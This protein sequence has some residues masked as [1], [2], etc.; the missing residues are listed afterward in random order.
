MKR[1]QNLEIAR[2]LMYY[3]RTIA[4]F[5]GNTGETT[6]L[7]L[8]RLFR[9]NGWFVYEV[10]E[11]D[12]QQ[13][14]GDRIA[15]ILVICDADGFPKDLQPALERYLV[16]NGRVFLFG[17]P[18]SGLR[19]ITET[20][21]VLEG[22]SPLYKLYR[23]NDCDR[24]ETLPQCITS[25]GIRGEFPYAICPKAR[26]LG[27][28]YGN[29][30][31]CRMIPLVS[32]RKDGGRDGGKRGTVAYFM[33]SDT[34]GHMTCTPGTRLG[35]VSPITQGSA[36]AV[37]GLPL[38]SVLETCGE[39]I[40][41]MMRALDRGIF[42]F[43][44]GAD[45]YVIRP[46]EEIHVG[47][48]IVSASRD[49]QEVTVRFCIDGAVAERTV[50]ATGQNYTTVTA[51]LN[52]LKKGT[53]RVCT[54]LVLSETVIDRV[55]ST[56]FV[57]DGIHTKNRDDFVTVRDGNFWLQDKKWYLYGI[58]YFP[59]Y[60]I[61]LEINDYWRGVFDKSDYIPSEVEKDLAHIRSLGMNTVSVRIDCN[62]F[63]NI[64]QP[65]KDF[66]C[67]CARH[68]LKVMM[69]FCNITNP[70]YFDEAA[71]AEF[72][73]QLDVSDDPT[74]LA[75]DIFWESGGGFVGVFNSRKF[76]DEWRVWLLEH[77]G[78]FD[79]AEENFGVPLDRTP[80]GEVICPASEHYYKRDFECG[81]MMSA[82]T[83]FCTE[84]VGRKWNY[85]IR[86]MKRYDNN[87]LYTNRIGH[88]DDTTP[89]VFLSAAA[90][91][92]DFM[93]LES[94]SIT[95]DDTGFL[96]SVA[97]DRAADCVSGGK[98]VAW[99]EYGISLSGMS[100]LAF[101]SK[102]LWNGELNAPLEWRLEE[103]RAYQ[104]QFNAV[105][106]M[107]NSKGTM[108]W[109]YPGGFRYTEFSDCG[110]VSPNGEL[111]PAMEEYL[112][113]SDQFG[114]Q[115]TETPVLET[116]EADPDGDISHWCTFV[117]GTGVFSKFVYDR[118]RLIENTS[119]KDTRVPGLGIR[120]ADRT[121]KMGGTFRFK[122]A[123]SE[124]TSADTPLLLCGNSE[125][126]GYGPLKYLDGEFNS[127]TLSNGTDTYEISNG[128]VCS[129]PAGEYG[130]VAEIGNI[131]PAKWLH[132]DQAGCVAL[133]CN[134]QIFPLLRDTEYLEDGRTEGV[135]S[136]REDC[137][138]SL[139]L[140]AL[141]RADF[142]EIFRFCLRV[143]ENA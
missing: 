101:G 21:T 7:A 76:A 103:Q 141:G 140:T 4:L 66:F 122:L 31:R 38:D 58:N 64:I 105:F 134:G 70:L 62:S 71:F 44:G 61:S 18:L 67:R 91:H 88:L 79:C 32:V 142:G 96:A 10:T 116:V 83:R 104:E 23:E 25:A 131:A 93:C 65:L 102:V 35:N 37:I 128:A 99:V 127:V 14:G 138:V 132:G 60:H 92:L 98:P 110:Y 94:Y 29:N 1:T 11:E 57:T 19:D 135:L 63:E 120:A 109:F 84:M 95:Q 6:F 9:E 130:L 69:S 126:R 80:A 117:F 123:G 45:Q 41:D 118:A 15:S 81:R 90:K 74:L 59:L 2:S 129:L 87:H 55:E 22:V 42:L 30:R 16:E 75:H 3:D 89:N 115:R 78:S 107:C 85:A 26:P 112:R 82:F 17:G 143:K 46:D 119:I 49:F 139:R 47:A 113:V 133:Q 50:L 125:Y 124:T 106:R 36:I 77:Y 39:L 43:E 53:Y 51:Y 72:M 97:L 27:E 40:V 8:E 13:N 86:R 108:P 56:L 48:K 20:A 52:G 111:R 34:I 136:V 24:F 5:R 33:L 54:E 137:T 121:R 73:R 28:G 68:G 114:E 100:G 12:L